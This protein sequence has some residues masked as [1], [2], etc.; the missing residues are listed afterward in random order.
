MT[1]GMTLSSSQTTVGNLADLLREAD[2]ALAVQQVM[3]S[4]RGV[5]RLPISWT[6]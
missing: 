4:Q 2:A 6:A 3:A 5:K 1:S